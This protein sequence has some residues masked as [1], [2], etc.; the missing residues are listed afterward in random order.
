MSQQQPDLTKLSS[1]MYRQWESAVGD[2]WDKVLESPTFLGAMGDQVA[3]QSKLRKGYEEKV[4]ESM[5]AM[6][7]PSRKDM[8]RLA[9]IATLLE[10]KLLSLEDRLLAVDD[11]LVALDTRLDQME[12]E[13]LRAR[14]DA[15]EARLAAADRLTSLEDKI[16]A[17]T[18][19]LG[20]RGRKTRA[21]AGE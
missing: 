15:A 8:V 19:A 6:H 3:A 18:A 21:P 1:D 12:R 20:E 11:R 17:L 4:D 5:T 14:V 10:D 7:L 9:R 13:S 2:W 16:D